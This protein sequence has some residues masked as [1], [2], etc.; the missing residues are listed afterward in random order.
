MANALA[1]AIL[2]AGLARK[3]Q[4]ICSDVLA[5]RT[6]QM[7]EQYG[8]SVARSNQEVVEQADVLIVA[9]KPQDFT[10]AAE[11][12]GPFVRAA[13]L[14]ISIMAGVPIQRVFKYLPGRVVRVMPNTPCA[15]GQM[16]AG[17]AAAQN[18][19]ERD[20]QLVKELLGSAGVAVEV[21]EEQLDAVTG[22]SGSGPAFVAHL[23]DSFIK[24]G[25]QVG[26]DA[27]V[28]RR[29]TLKTFEGTAR[30]L[31]EQNIQ[32]TDLIAMVSSPNGTTVAGRAVLEQSD[33]EDIIAATVAAA[34]ERSKQLGRQID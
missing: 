26:L 27:E 17:F 16:A 30:L 6:G 24:A 11:P 2:R 14:I 23:I 7:A 31:S 1:G 13:Q 8:V 9:V 3:D 5:E 4:I 22:L 28:S 21:A 19:T 32:P 29:L 10:A 33:V 15:V 18:V 25:V 34:T 12:L 20:K